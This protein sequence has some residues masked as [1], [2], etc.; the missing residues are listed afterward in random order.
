MAGPD[1]DARRRAAQLFARGVSRAESARMLGVSRATTTRWYRIWQ[2]GGVLALTTPAPRGRPAKLEAR[3]LSVVHAA[4]VESPRESGF[5]LD[6]WSLAAVVALIERATNI[7]Y[8]PR[9]VARVLRR[10]G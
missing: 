2:A 1:T 3:D 10:A 6:H 4:L 8:H 7:A 9:H 5:P